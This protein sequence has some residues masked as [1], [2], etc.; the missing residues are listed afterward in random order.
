[1][2]HPLDDARQRCDYARDRYIHLQ[3]QI[4][5]FRETSL[6]IEFRQEFD[7]ATNIITV[8][9]ANQVEYPVV[10]ALAISEILHNC[11]VAL[12]YVAWELRNLHQT[13]IGNVSLDDYY[14]MFIIE[15]TQEKFSQS[16]RLNLLDPIHVL[17]IENFQPFG[18]ISIAEGREA[19]RHLFENKPVDQ[20][21]WEMIDSIVVARHPLTILANLEKQDKH[22]ILKRVVNRAQE[23][24]LNEYEG[25]DCD[26]VSRINFIILEIEKDA[27]WAE[28]VV[29]PTGANPT[30]WVKDEVKTN[31]SFAGWPLTVVE[32]IFSSIERIIST[33]S[34]VF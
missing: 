2:A 10:W 18:Q 23:S 32:P 26:V 4:A 30:L 9:V 24:H 1:M 5:V 22:K 3:S 34:L 7:A 13:K 8:F 33:F 12:D 25:L 29:E 17:M 27:K 11:R 20:V 28:C 21:D 31:V 19:L 16:K 15:P 6:A 14:T